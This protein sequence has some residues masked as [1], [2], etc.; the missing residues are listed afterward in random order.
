MPEGPARVLV[1][2]GA[3]YIGAALVAKLLGLKEIDL[4][5]SLDLAHSRTYRQALDRHASKKLVTID[6]DIREPL[7]A[8][9]SEHG[10]NTVIHLVFLLQTHRD[11][12]Y[13]H[14]INVEA[15]GQLLE[16]IA[17]T[18]VKRFVYLS[19]TTVYGASASNNRPF[20][21]SD[22]TLPTPGFQYSRHKVETERIIS[23]FA[24]DHPEPDGV[25]ITVLRACPVMS[26]GASNFIS[27]SLGMKFLP[28]PMGHDPDMQFIHLDDLLAAIVLVLQAENAAGLFNIAGEGTVRWS[29]LARISGATRIPVPLALL[30]SVISAGWALR[31]QNKSPGPGLALITYPWLASTERALVALGWKPEFTSRQAVEIWSASR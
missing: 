20:R 9:I 21:E 1:T 13:A 16:A 22:R 28:V 18:G 19:S 7:A 10:V 25:K 5:V 6:Q 3:G 17:E 14:S 8:V 31:L 4:V 12:A 2:G 30:K 26:P 11:E 23:Q 15:T 27:E 24:N 29:E